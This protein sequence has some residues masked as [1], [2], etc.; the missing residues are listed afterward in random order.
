MKNASLNRLGLITKV[1]HRF[2]LAMNQAGARH[3]VIGGKAMQG[4]G[5]LRPTLDLDVWVSTTGFTPHQVHAVLRGLADAS[6]ESLLDR[7]H[8]SGTRVALPNET[9]PDIDILTSVGDMEFDE[10]FAA[11]QPVRF[12]AIVFRIPRREDLIRTKEAGINALTER[13]VAGAWVAP[14][15]EKALEAVTRDRADI[16]LIRNSGR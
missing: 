9:E 5:I 10:I 4:L 2:I 14:D 1:Q 6:S 12:G 16:E 15:L 11:S 3:V 13:I 8:K 7:L